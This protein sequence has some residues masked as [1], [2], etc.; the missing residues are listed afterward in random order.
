M[1]LNRGK[2]NCYFSEKDLITLVHPGS[3]FDKVESYYEDVD[4]VPNKKAVMWVNS[5]CYVNAHTANASRIAVAGTVLALDKV[6]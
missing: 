2:H 4:G 3:Y 1:R 5:D 6:V